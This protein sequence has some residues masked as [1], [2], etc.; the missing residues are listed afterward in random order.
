MPES[1]YDLG[2]SSG[3]RVGRRI[4][5]Q[6]VICFGDPGVTWDGSASLSLQGTRRATIYLSTVK[7]SLGANKRRSCKDVRERA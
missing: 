1:A 2:Y 3:T 6:G 7:A 5:S 4:V